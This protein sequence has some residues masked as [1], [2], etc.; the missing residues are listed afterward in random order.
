MKTLARALIRYHLKKP[1]LTSICIIGVALGVTVVAGIQLANRSAL[2]AFRQAAAA[3]NGRA[4]HS[5][6]S[7]GGVIREHVY[8]DLVRRFPTLPAAPVVRTSIPLGE[9]TAVLMGVDPLAEVHLRPDFLP[10]FSDRQLLD[11][12]TVPQTVIINQ[13]AEKFVDR[14]GFITVALPRQP[15]RPLSLRVVGTLDGSRC[16]A[17]E[18]LILGDISWVQTMYPGR[19][20][21]SRIDLLAKDPARLRAVKNFLPAHLE[22]QSSRKRQQTLT[23]M[24][25]SFELNITALSLLSLFVGFFLIYNT[26]TFMVLQRRRETGI[27]QALGFSR[28][29]LM[30]ALVVEVLCL[31]ALG[32]LIGAAWGYWLAKYSLVIISRTITDLYFSLPRAEVDCRLPFILRCL[33]IGIGAGSCAV[34]LPLLEIRHSSIARL[35]SRRTVEDRAG[36]NRWRFA[37]AGLLLILFSLALSR[38][39]GQEPYFG[40]AAAFGICLGFALTTPLLTERLIFFF[41]RLADPWLGIRSKLGIGA[42]SRRL[43]RTAPAISALMVAL[44]MSMGISLMIGSFRGTLNDWFHH[45]VQGDFYVSGSDR[46]YDAN[47][48][49]RDL[50][51]ELQT[52]PGI[53]AVNRYRNISYRFRD[54]IVRLTGM[55][56]DVMKNHSRYQFL[57]ARGQPWD[58]L[59]KGKV[60]VS[61]SFANKYRV[62]PGDRIMLRGISEKKDFE[63]AAVYRDYVTEHGVIIMNYALFSRFMDDREVNSLAIFLRPGTSPAAFRR[64]LLPRLRPYPH[65]LYTNASLRKRIME[66][67]DRS[68]TITISTRFIAVVVAFFGII[69]ALLSMYLESEREYGILRALGLSRGD[70]FRLSLLQSVTMGLLAGLLAWLCGPVLAWVLIKVINLKSFGWTIDMHLNPMVFLS[71]LGIAAAASLVSGLYPAWRIAGSNPYFQM[72]DH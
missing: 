3:L 26:I 31:A 53:A 63:V 32:S 42:I 67:F 59:K 30:A 49:N 22:L 28:L 60:M 14:G 61:E 69:S 25:K 27:L 19:G 44:A 24:L 34:I 52:L 11:F 20:K 35:L 13:P 48:L 18:P 40:F 21:L 43:S 39:P 9:E 12:L 2:D 8:V 45:N 33:A 23:G 16:A 66:I 47:T 4:T 50:Y 29:Q 62:K 54:G 65:I 58:E 55:D 56:A 36:S 57:A 41:L 10:H 64:R 15:G 70:V 72:Q 7:P 38:A 68:F 46:D 1:L 6:S 51:Q 71:T 17:M 5:I 37:L